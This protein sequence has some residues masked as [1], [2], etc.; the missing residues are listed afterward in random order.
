MHGNKELP[1]IF[2]DLT[3]YEDNDLIQGS[4]Q[5]L[6]KYYTTE[7]K[8]LSSAYQTQLLTTDESI[9]LYNLIETVVLSSLRELLDVKN[10]MD[11]S[12]SL[13]HFSGGVGGGGGGS[14]S[15]GI[16]ALDM[17]TRKCW[18]QGEVIGSE[19]H[20]QNQKIVYNFGKSGYAMIVHTIIARVTYIFS[21]WTLPCILMELAL[22]YKSSRRNC[23]LFGEN[24]LIF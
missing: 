15:D 11:S 18:I 3:N 9:S 17:L 10:V 23:P 13:I 5:L 6:D 12:R 1:G 16:S 19:P 24:A 21:S 2:L 22:Q 4:L 8:L 14:G 7:E 20:Q